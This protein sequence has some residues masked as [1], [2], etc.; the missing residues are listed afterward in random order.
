MDIKVD[1][2]GRVVSAEYQ[3]RGS[4]TSDASMKA[5]AR[6][7]AMQVRF[8][9]GAAESVGTIVFNFRLKN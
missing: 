4:T 8:S 7:K 2:T 5:I 3:P 9:T 6:R 1:E